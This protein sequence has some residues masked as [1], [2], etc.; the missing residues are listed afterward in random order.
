MLKTFKNLGPATL[1]AAAFIGPG[2]V[3]VCAGA[4]IGFGYSLLWALLVSIVITILLQEMAVRIGIVTQKGLADV[5]REQLPNPYIKAI[6]IS[7]ILGAIVIGNA[8]YEAGNMNGA[9]LGL[10]A[11]VGEKYT[12]SYPWVVGVLAFSMLYFGTLKQW[13]RLLIALVVMMSISFLITALLTGPNIAALLKGL[14]LP[15][16]NN[17]NM[18]TIIALVGTTVVPYNLF[19]HAALVKERWHSKEGLK[20]ATLDTYIAIGLGGL[21]SMAIVVS[22]AGI[23]AKSLTSVL[24]LAQGLVPLYGRVAKYGIG[25]GL[26]GAGLTS[27]VTAPLAAAYVANSCFNWQVST[28]HWKFRTVW[29]GVMLLG[30]LSLISTYSPIAIIQFAQVANGVLLPILVIVLIWL[31]NKQQVL[32]NFKN[33]L[34]QNILYGV[35]LI[36]SLS[37]SFKTLSKIIGW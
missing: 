33:S 34:S 28:K 7:L 3:T 10:Q 37:L 15:S 32:G 19:L 13:T 1:V 2:T 22:A 12:S 31:C 30:F 9:I 17:E 24:D 23:N 21:I 11:L 14:L 35:I 26:F 4:G 5:I 36:F 27:A 8:A 6:I 16:M 20:A 29:M 25:I 18:L